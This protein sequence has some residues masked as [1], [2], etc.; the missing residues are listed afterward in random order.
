MF[1]ICHL[2]MVSCHD[3]VA[4]CLGSSARAVHK[5]P[6]V[7]VPSR[8]PTYQTVQIGKNVKAA[9]PQH[10]SRIEVLLETIASG[11]G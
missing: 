8:G 3:E 9:K 2:L 5:V 1:S 7:P 11:R 10:T 4:A 6:Y